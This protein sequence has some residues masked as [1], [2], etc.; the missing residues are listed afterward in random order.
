M[1]ESVETSHKSSTLY[2]WSESTGTIDWNA[3]ETKYAYGICSDALVRVERSR[4]YYY[5][6]YDGEPRE[7]CRVLTLNS[8]QKY[9]FVEKLY[10]GIDKEV[11]TWNGMM[12]TRVVRL[13]KIRLSCGLNIDLLVSDETEYSNWADAIIRAVKDSVS[14]QS[15]KGTRNF[16]WSCASFRHKDVP[17]KQKNNATTRLS[18]LTTTNDFAKYQHFEADGTEIKSSRVPRN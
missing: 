15:S 4:L 3:Y 18:V 1:D 12:R 9:R 14:V 2:S 8:K 5:K 7:L 17:E 16:V 6:L 13:S 10:L 11:L